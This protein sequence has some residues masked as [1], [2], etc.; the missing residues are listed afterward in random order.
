MFDFSPDVSNCRNKLG[1]LLLSVQLICLCTR[2]PQLYKDT[3]KS[4]SYYCK[5]NEFANDVVDDIFFYYALL[6]TAA[7]VIMS[8]QKEVHVKK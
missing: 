6:Q 4:S 7:N 5:Q 8:F 2:G 1:R 3:E